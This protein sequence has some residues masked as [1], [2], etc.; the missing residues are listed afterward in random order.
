MPPISLS[1]YSVV[2]GELIAVRLTIHT[3]AEYGQVQ[4]E[5]VTAGVANP[6]NKLGFGTTP[7]RAKAGEIEADIDTQHLGVGI[8]EIGLVRLHSPTVQSAVPQLDFVPRRDFSRQVFDVRASTDAPRTQPELLAHVVNLEEEI[9]QKFA[10]PISLP[11][12]ASSP[13]QECTVLVFLRDILVGVGMRFDHFELVPTNSGL[14]GDDAYRFVNTFLRSKTATDIQFEADDAA[15]ENARRNNPVCVLHFP[16]I[17]GSSMEQARDYCVEQANVL[18]L[19]LSLSRDAGGVVF[20]VVV[21][22]KT[23]GS[24][25]KYAIASPYI[26]NLLT[27]HLAGESFESVR[28]YANGLA[29]SETNRFLVGLYKDARRERS[30]DFQYVRYWQILETMAE[31]R[32]YDSKD[33]LRDFS[34]APMTDN[35]R[36]RFIKGSVN[37]VFNLLRE[38]QIGDTAST[39]KNVNTWFAFRNAVAHHGAVSRYTDL[40]RD[41]VREWARLGYEELQRSPGHDVF[42]WSLKEEVKLLLMRRLVETSLGGPPATRTAA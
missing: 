31:G 9:E 15:R 3:E 10:Q 37:I 17:R 30:A 29:A 35:G 16:S 33:A 23:S 36:V 2:Q 5:I 27:G 25:V 38:N 4:I 20:D 42:L 34:G 21:L 19:A 24:A 39:W 28:H 6:V 41:P 12:D 26:G 1:Q 11:A 22:S 32:N 18:L 8:Y 14:E 13:I 40:S 7:K